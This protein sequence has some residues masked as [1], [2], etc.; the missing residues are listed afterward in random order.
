MS[1][2]QGRYLNTEQHKQN[3]RIHTQN[4]DALSGIRTH[5]PSVERALDRPVTV[6]GD[7]N[8]KTANN[9]WKLIV[10]IHLCVVLYYI[11]FMEYRIT[12]GKNT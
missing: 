2:S 12:S 9:Q 5:D 6:T 10:C 3:K 1:P 4:T 8:H 7:T 11:P